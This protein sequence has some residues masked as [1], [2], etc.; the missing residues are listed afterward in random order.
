MS[1]FYGQAGVGV[2]KPVFEG[3]RRRR[4]R[5]THPVHERHRH[6]VMYTA[7]NAAPSPNSANDQ[8]SKGAAALPP[9]FVFFMP[10]VF[11]HQKHLTFHR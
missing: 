2:P 4:Y 5:V 3:F 9:G 11:R 6:L 10:L 8:A 1:V 7:D